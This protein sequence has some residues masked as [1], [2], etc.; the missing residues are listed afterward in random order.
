VS[1]LPERRALF[2]R[3]NCSPDPE[4][5]DQDQLYLLTGLD[6]GIDLKYYDEHGKEYPDWNSRQPCDGKRLPARV[7]ITLLLADQRGQ[8]HPF[9]MMTD[10]ELTR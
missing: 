2:L 10:F 6:H 3:L 7:K 8:P 9:V 5:S 1:E 4:D